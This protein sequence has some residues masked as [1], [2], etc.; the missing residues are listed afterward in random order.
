MTKCVR[1]SPF[2]FK[3]SWFIAVKQWNT[4]RSLQ[5]LVIALTDILGILNEC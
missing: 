2:D 4:N 3:E 1:D 5:K